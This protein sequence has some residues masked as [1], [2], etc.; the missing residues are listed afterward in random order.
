MI[1][2]SLPSTLMRGRWQLSLTATEKRLGGDALLNNGAVQQM[3][4]AGFTAIRAEGRRQKGRNADIKSERQEAALQA[5]L[6]I[7][8]M[9]EK[10]T[11]AVRRN[12]NEMRRC[13]V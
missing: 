6:Q 8:P 9:V 13:E 2:E 10:S 4:N 5:N 12:G 3:H 7:W 11:G 1:R